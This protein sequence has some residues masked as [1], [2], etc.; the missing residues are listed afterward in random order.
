MDLE[1]IGFK[2]ELPK[3]AEAN[4]VVKLIQKVIDEITKPQ[5]RDKK[6]KVID[7]H[8]VQYSFNDVRELA[9]LIERE[10]P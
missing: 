6:Y 9:I 8:F 4:G 2:E 5:N 1:T 7:A 3:L 10:T